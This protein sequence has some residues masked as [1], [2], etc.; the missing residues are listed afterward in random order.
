MK[1]FIGTENG[2]EWVDL[3]L[4]TGTKWATCNIGATKPEEIGDHFAWG[5]VKP[6]EGYSFLNY[7]YNSHETFKLTR[8]N[9][10]RSEGEN[11]FVD[12]KTT[13][14]L[15]DDAAYVNWGGKWM[16][17][18]MVQQMELRNEC[19][20]EWTED[21]NGSGVAGFIVYKAKAEAD[22]GVIYKDET[23][24]SSYSLGDAHIFLPAAGERSFNGDLDYA[25][26]DGYYWSSSLNAGRPQNAWIVIFKS[27]DASNYK[28]GFRDHGYSVRAVIPGE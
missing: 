9:T 16:M 24:S 3:G 4:P 26:S 5:E 17:P 25:G 15:E 11:G 22:K 7:K 18:T 23:P 10:D 28:G 1:N 13:L 8:Y 27:D 14:N 12:N 6:K 2:H 20:W 19:Y 21:Y